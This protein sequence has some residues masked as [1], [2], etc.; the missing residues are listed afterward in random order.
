MTSATTPSIRHLEPSPAIVSVVGAHPAKAFCFWFYFYVIYF[1][2]L[3]LF[4]PASLGSSLLFPSTVGDCVECR[5]F[6]ARPAIVRVRTAASRG[7]SPG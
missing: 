1:W 2:D 4:V 3:V 6:F 5:Q 7:P